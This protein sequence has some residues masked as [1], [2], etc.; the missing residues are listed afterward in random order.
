MVYKAFCIR[1]VKSE[2]YSSPFFKSTHGEAERDFRSMCN[3]EKT[4]MNKYPEDY[5]LYYCGEY[6][7]SKGIFV[8]LQEATHLVKAIDLIATT[9]PIGAVQE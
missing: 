4:M 8:P 9:T 3:D 2:S 6:D 7:D 5:S 1:D